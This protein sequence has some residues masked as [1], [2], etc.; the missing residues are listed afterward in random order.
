LETIEINNAKKFIEIISLSNDKYYKSN[1]DYIFRG[2]ANSKWELIPSILREKTKLYDE[3]GQIKKDEFWSNRNQI[4]VEFFMINEF[5]KELNLSGFHIPNEETLNII[6]SSEEYIH[7]I[8]N[9]G[10]GKAWPTKEYIGVLSIAQH[11]G[12]PTRFIDFTYD[13][14]V[15]LYFAAKSS[16]KIKKSNKIAVYAL[17]KDAYE[18]SKYNFTNINDL[19]TVEKSASKEYKLYQLVNTAAYYNIN[20][21]SQKALFLSYVHYGFR[22]NEKSKPFSIEEYLKNSN[23]NTKSYKFIIDSKFSK[24]LL[25]LLNKKFYNV[26]TLFPS[27]ESCVTNTFDKLK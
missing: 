3:S 2:Q 8:S 1:H 9:L 19:N 7:F 16:L 11:Y 12:I 15:A 17:D 24:E 22:A 5:V 21:K 27:I 10:R 6:N 25:F 4:E 14:L 26:S 13:P 20:L 18:F 23:T